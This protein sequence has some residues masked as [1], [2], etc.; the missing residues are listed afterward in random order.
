MN[1]LN[2]V[3]K[4]I[5][6]ALAVGAV[7]AASL[8]SPAWAALIDKQLV[9]NVVQVCDNA[10]NNCASLGPVG[11]SYFEAEADKIW[12]QAGIDIKFVFTGTL[13][14][15]SL[16]NGSTGIDAITGPLAGPGTTM[17]L[18]N[19]ISGVYGN[20]WLDAGGLAINMSD[21]MSFNGGIGRLDTIAHE[22][23]H[24]LGLDHFEVANN[25]MASGGV[26]S[27]PINISQI[28]PGDGCVDFLT[29]DQI[30][31]VRDSR[32]LIDF[33]AEPGNVPEPAS[34]ALLGAALAAAGLARRRRHV[35]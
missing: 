6:R 10:G 27:V 33:Q 21:V 4:M 15:S 16:L 29:A 19:T 14:S 23:G 8:S 24:N 12:A 11:N 18:M 35:R 5:P 13:N 26:R 31:N 34:M 1:I 20:A 30:A 7:L 3:Q 17:Y 25:L 9:V 32:L 2:T 22:L 28:C